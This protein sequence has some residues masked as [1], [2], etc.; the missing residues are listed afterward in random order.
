MSTYC[1]IVPIH[2]PTPA[3]RLHR[4]ALNQ[5]GGLIPDNV[6][7]T[8]PWAG[9]QWTDPDGHHWWVM[10]APAEGPTD[11]TALGLIRRTAHHIHPALA[12]WT[13]H[14]PD[15]PDHQQPATPVALIEPVAPRARKDA[16]RP[17]LEQLQDLIH[18][19]TSVE[20][21][22]RRCGWTRTGSAAVAARRA[23]NL[24]LEAA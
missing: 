16:T 2:T 23:G 18:A 12:A 3:P 8:G 10:T 21:T 19:G 14:T 24:T 9:H 20:D 7:I 15:E 4:Q 6:T 5:L 22:I 17:R 1:A 13:T 11:T